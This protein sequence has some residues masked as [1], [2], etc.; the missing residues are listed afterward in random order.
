MKCNENDSL[1]QSSILLDDEEE[2][3]GAL[4]KESDCD[5]GRSPPQSELLK[6]GG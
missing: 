5:H 3:D 2:E 4:A 6:D 1:L